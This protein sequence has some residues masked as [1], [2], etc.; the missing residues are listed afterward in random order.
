MDAIRMVMLAGSIG[1]TLLGSLYAGANAERTA[2]ERAAAP[3]PIVSS[4]PRVEPIPPP[5][6][7]AVS[8]VS[9][10]LPDT[11]DPLAI[12]VAANAQDIVDEQ[13][14]LRI[15]PLTMMPRDLEPLD[16]EAEEVEQAEERVP[17][18]RPARRNRA[19]RPAPGPRLHP[20]P[21]MHVI[22]TARG[23]MARREV[24]SGSCY[25]YLS[26]VYDRAGHS[27]WRNRRTVYQGNRNGPYASLDQVRPG[28]W[29]Y[30][31]NHPDRT[32]VG[33]HSVLFVGWQ[34]R[35]RGQAHVIE[36]SGWG[37]PSAGRERTYDISR[38][39]RITR[40]TLRR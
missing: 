13:T 39:Y 15:G 36:H 34:D 21:G 5:V 19:P 32:P 1:A 22:L 23:M 2:A 33:T 4:S 26:E 3:A 18:A 12:A 8:P 30:I 24:V 11:R 14:G 29:L 25:R 35:A 7:P 27:G 17:S 10:P 40:P 9:V 31:V 38:T 6:P 37:A 28:D 20:D 16:E